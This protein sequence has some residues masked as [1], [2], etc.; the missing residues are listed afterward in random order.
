MKIEHASYTNGPPPGAGQSSDSTH[1]TS[2]HTLSDDPLR[3]LEACP[4]CGFLIQ[5]ILWGRTNCPNC[6]LHFEC[7]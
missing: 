3:D 5:Q 6:G 2:V 4:R 7:C 1:A